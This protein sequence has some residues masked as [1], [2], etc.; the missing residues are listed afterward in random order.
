MSG[1]DHDAV[2]AEFFAGTRIK[3]NFIVNIGR[4]TQEGLH[5]RLPRLDF[6]EAN[7]VF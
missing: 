3:S 7:W 6:E 4:G 5:G 2:D 1:F